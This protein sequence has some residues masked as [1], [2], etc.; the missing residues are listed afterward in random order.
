MNTNVIL[1]PKHSMN[2]QD[3]SPNPKLASLKELTRS[4]EQSLS[5][6]ETLRAL[7]R[8]FTEAD[9][10][11]AS[12]LLSTRGMGQGH[13]RVVRLQ[14]TDDPQES[15]FASVSE[16]QSPVQSGG[17]VAAITARSG[18]QL[19][20]DVDWSPDR[21]FN[22]ILHGYT[23]VIAIPIFG[24]R[25]PMQLHHLL[26]RSRRVSLVSLTKVAAGQFGQV[27]IRSQQSNPQ[28]IFARTHRIKQAQ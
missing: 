22:E 18:P 11:V 28:M 10:F 19:I 25:L 7:H 14:L 1:P 3:V 9:G 20:Q 6:D 15:V 12:I 16:E 2:V 21:F 24:D 17:I 5:P 13:Y 4:L 26:D 27:Y 23:S 8:G